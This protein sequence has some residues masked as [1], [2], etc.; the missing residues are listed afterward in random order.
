M[1]DLLEVP[2]LDYPKAQYVK[3]SVTAVTAGMDDESFAKAMENLIL[4]Q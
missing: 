3:K 1:A 4:S 2:P